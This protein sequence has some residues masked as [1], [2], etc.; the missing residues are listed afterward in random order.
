MTTNH[1]GLRGHF[2]L[3]QSVRI[4]YL[5]K[6]YP[7]WTAVVVVVVV[8]GLRREDTVVKVNLIAVTEC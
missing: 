8:V 6:P 5:K 2:E 3:F 7:A 1:I 4:N